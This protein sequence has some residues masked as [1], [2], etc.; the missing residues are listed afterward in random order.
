M[1]SIG[2]GLGLGLSLSLSSCMPR[3][4]IPIQQEADMLQL[5]PTESRTHTAA[6]ICTICEWMGGTPKTPKQQLRINL[7]W[8][9]DYFIF[10]LALKFNDDLLLKTV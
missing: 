2:L 1:D 4:D 6:G 8:R 9:I 5:F 10:V 3:P 7:T